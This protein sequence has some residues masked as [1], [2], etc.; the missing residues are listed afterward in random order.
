MFANYDSKVP[1]VCR[2]IKSIYGLKQSPRKWFLKFKSVLLPYGFKQANS[3]HSLFILPTS[4]SFMVVLVYVDDI[5]VVENNP[6]AIAQFK[7][8][9]ASYFKIKDLGPVKYFLGIEAARSD[10]GIYLN[11]RKYTWDIIKDVGLEN[12]KIAIIPI[13]QNHTLLSN[14]TTHFLFNPAPYRRLVGHLIHLTITRPDLSYVVHVLSQFLASPRQCHLDAA[15]KVVRYLKYTFGQGILLSASSTLKLSAYGDADWGG[16]P[17]TR[18]SLT[19]YCVTLGPS[20]L[21]WK[22]KRQNMMGIL[23]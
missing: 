9:I 1:L 14:T 5:L 6:T 18:Q 13:E 11:Q 21:S 17:L 22:S 19:G 2:L 16:C 23:H 7:A 8:H 15:H 10:K 12:S 4:T 3:D 20:L